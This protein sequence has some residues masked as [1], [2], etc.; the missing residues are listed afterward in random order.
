M[1]DQMIVERAAARGMTPN[2]YMAGNLLGVEVTASDMA[3]AFLHLAQMDKVNAAVLHRRRRRD[4][5]VAAVGEATAFLEIRDAQDMTT[6]YDAPQDFATTALAGYCAIHGRTVRPASGAAW[7]VRHETHEGQGFAGRRR[8]LRP[9]PGLRRLCR[10]GL[11]RRGRCR[12]VLASPSTAAVARVCRH[13]D[14]GGGTTPRLRQLCRRRAEFQR[15]CRAA[16]CRR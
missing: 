15:G 11:C 6:I 1:T 16:A 8:Q 9:L 12:H 4:G 2:E 7:C 5:D 10:A 13:A 14:L 3:D